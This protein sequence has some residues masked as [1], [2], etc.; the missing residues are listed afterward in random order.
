MEL[1]TRGSVCGLLHG[2][3]RAEPLSLAMSAA[4]MYDVAKGMLYL[5]KLLPRVL[6]H[7]LKSLNLLL[8]DGLVVKIC[9]FGLAKVKQSS[10]SSTT[11]AKGTAAWM[12]PECFE[13]E[14]VELWTRASDVYSFGVV[15]YEFLARQLPWPKRKEAQIALAVL[16]GL[17]PTLPDGCEP[18]VLRVLMERCWDQ[19]PARRPTFDDV[20]IA[21]RDAVAVLGGEIREGS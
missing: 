20:A 7:D 1:A 9:D 2:S 18:G 15:M 16:K 21:L 5:H 6:H 4:M 19:L 11:R 13:D 12:P 10:M 17:R 14:E 8:F 3:R